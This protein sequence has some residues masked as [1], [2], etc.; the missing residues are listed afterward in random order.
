MPDEIT[1]RV[2]DRIASLKRI[3]V[4]QVSICGSLEDLGLDSLDAINLLFDL[5]NKFSISIPDEEVRS[6]R[7]LNDIVA[8]VKRRLILASGGSTTL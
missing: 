2:L 8:C 4:E 7:T 3:P 1:E 5:E 6:I